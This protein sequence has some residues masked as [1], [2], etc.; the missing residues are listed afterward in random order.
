[1]NHLDANMTIVD[2]NQGADMV[3]ALPGQ[4]LVIQCNHTIGRDFIR[5]LVG[6]GGGAGG[7]VSYRGER[8]PLSGPGLSRLVGVSCLDDGLYERLKVREYLTF[9]MELHDIRTGIEDWLRPI[10]L[11]EKANER[12]SKLNYSEKRLLGFTRSILHDPEFVIWEDPEQNLDL[13]SIMMVKRMISGLIQKDKAVLVTCST[14]EQALSLSNRIFRLGEGVLTPFTVLEQLEFSEPEIDTPVE[15][16]SATE[17][18]ELQEHAMRL[19]KLMVKT[20]DKYVFIDP[21]DIRYIESLEGVTHIYTKDGGA[22]CTWS[23]A[24]L[25][26]RLRPF[27]FYRCHRSYIVNLD[28]ITELIV[29]SRNSYSL[30]LDDEKKSRIPL[31]KGKFDEL[32]TIVGL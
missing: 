2:T 20:D 21:Q 32:K 17:N 3:E 9:W 7:K 15:D 24:E 12:I 31:S 4:C 11:W 16:E 27:R 25:E 30:V 26:S 6:E 8:L 10:G 18:S 29:W 1:M 28:R 22:S 5:S 14:L 19:A 13:E 23:L